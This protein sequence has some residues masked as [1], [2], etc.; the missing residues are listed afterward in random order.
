MLK[1]DEKWLNLG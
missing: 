1:F